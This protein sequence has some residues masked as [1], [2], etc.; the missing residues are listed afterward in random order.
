MEHLYQTINSKA[1][2]DVLNTV[3]GSQMAAALG[4]M[5]VLVDRSMRDGYALGKLDG[6]ANTEG[7]TDAAFDTGYDEGYLN[8]VADARVRPSL[9]DSTVVEIIS[10]A[11]QYALNGEYDASFVTDSGDETN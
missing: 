11:A 1:L 4:K 8:G 3:F 2:D 5:Y 7:R 10:D 6:E 9:A